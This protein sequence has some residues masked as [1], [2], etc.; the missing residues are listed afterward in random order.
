TDGMP[1]SLQLAGPA[2]GEAAILR[3]GDAFQQSTDWHLRVPRPAGVAA[4]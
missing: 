4:A 1:L 2:F 3:V